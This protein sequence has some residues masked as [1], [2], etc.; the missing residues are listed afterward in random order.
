MWMGH[1]G[2][3]ISQ[4]EVDAVA[5]ARHLLATE[6][7][8]LNER[9][10]YQSVG[11]RWARDRERRAAAFAVLSGEGWMRR[12]TA[13][14]PGRPRGDWDVS[15]LPRDRRRSGSNGSNGSKLDPERD[16]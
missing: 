12:P 9:E 2:L 1:S 5:I 16:F 13:A 3:A 4:A 6:A 8:R 7:S 11:F 14:S 10:L 15:P